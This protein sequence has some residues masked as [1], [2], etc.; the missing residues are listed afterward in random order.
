MEGGKGGLGLLDWGER[1]LGFVGNKQCE[2]C[3]VG[4]GGKRGLGVCWRDDRK[5]F[6]PNNVKAAMLV[7]DHKKLGSQCSFL[8]KPFIY[9]DNL[10]Q[11]RRK[12]PYNV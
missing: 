10:R 11:W 4:R 5:V 6:D 1:G 7:E 12:L 2:R 3:H 8:V 9:I